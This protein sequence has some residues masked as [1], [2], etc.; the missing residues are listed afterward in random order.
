MF[1]LKYAPR[2]TWILTT[3]RH[4]IL[5]LMVKLI[6]TNDFYFTNKVCLTNAALFLPCSS[7]LRLQ[8]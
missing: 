1:H 7:V 5:M 3:E 6:L 2:S 4:G 8:E